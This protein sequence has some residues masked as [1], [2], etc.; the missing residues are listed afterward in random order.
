MIMT[1]C[2]VESEP[3]VSKKCKRGLILCTIIYVLLFPFLLYMGLLSSMVS[4]SP[5]ITPFFVGVIMFIVFCIPLSI[6][7]SI[8]LMWSRYFRKQYDKVH[9]FSRM[10]VYVMAG[11][12]ILLGIV[13]YLYQA[14]R[15]MFI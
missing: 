14:I 15:R 5:R 8:Y 11:V 1:N 10:P 3:T 13:P 2:P 6:P 4:D 7:V 12:F 9:L